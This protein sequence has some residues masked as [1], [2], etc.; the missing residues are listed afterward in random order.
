MNAYVTEDLTPTTAAIAL[1]DI[2]GSQGAN[3]AAKQF[4]WALLRTINVNGMFFTTDSKRIT[5]AQYWGLQSPLS[6]LRHKALRIRLI[7][8]I[9]P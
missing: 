8:G 2:Q 9:Q 5:I 6:R 7:F 4:A 1:Q 3:K